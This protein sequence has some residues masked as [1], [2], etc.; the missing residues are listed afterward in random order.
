M[1]D[2]L[3]GNCSTDLGIDTNFLNHMEDEIRISEER[4]E[5]QQRLDSMCQLLEK[6]QQTQSQRLSAPL[7]SNLNNCPPPTE[8]E[9]QM[10]ESITEN[11]TD[12]AKRVNPADVAPVPGNIC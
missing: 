9:N 11:L 10:A 2:L 6:L 7:P 5:L 12:I 8:D 3:T 4:H 1:C